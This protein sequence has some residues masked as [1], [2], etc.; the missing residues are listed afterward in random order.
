MVQASF[1]FIVGGLF[2][3]CSL[4]NNSVQSVY[5]LV[6]NRHGLCLHADIVVIIE[7]AKKR[8]RRKRRK[9]RRGGQRR[10]LQES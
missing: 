4:T 5:I 8:R 6:F 9:E 10:W 1:A 3:C 7:G 2:I